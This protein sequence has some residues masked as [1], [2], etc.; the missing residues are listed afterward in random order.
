MRKAHSGRQEDPAADG[1]HAVRLSPCT[2]EV[3]SR[4]VCDAAR[5]RQCECDPKQLVPAVGRE[6]ESPIVA[7]PRSQQEIVG[8][9]DTRL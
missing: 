6:F 5:P 8:E 9:A 7:P 2:G 3:A 4:R 1:H